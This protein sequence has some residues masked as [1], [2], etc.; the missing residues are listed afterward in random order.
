M[1]DIPK[2]ASVFVTDNEHV[3]G[4]N[5]GGP[6]LTNWR[7]AA[8]RQARVSNR[9]RQI[10]RKLVRRSSDVKDQLRQVRQQTDAQ[11]SFIETLLGGRKRSK[12]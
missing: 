3:A 11:L 5:V 1:P 7:D 8:F 2:S 9:R 12:E 6:E 10:I 4:P